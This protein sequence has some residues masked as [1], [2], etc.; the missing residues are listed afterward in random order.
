MHP[1][2]GTMMPEICEAPH[3]PVFP[4]IY[5]CAPYL[6]GWDVFITF[7][8]SRC[9]YFAF[10]ALR[11]KIDLLHLYMNLVDEL[12]TASTAY[13]YYRRPGQKFQSGRGQDWTEPVCGQS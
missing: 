1:V 4:F 5:H 10:F 11:N 12:F 3:L 9:S 8:E 13:F 7:P 2:L 6:M